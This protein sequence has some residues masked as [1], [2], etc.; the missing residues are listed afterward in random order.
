LTQPNAPQT[1][2]QTPNPVTSFEF[3][4]QV[5]NLAEAKKSD[6]TA[7]LDVSQISGFA[8][9]F[10]F[11]T[12]HSSTQ[13]T[14]IGHHIAEMLKTQGVV[15]LHYEDDQSGQ[16]HL[17]DYGDVV[18]HVMRDEARQHYDLEAYWSHGS[19]LSRDEWMNA[20]RNN[21]QQQRQSA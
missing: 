19:P 14:A 9:Y 13:I 16:W 20:G 10:V 3:A 11:A 5:A 21:A 8:D 17:L 6:N 4:C 15:P 12:G 18:V 2:T 7:I 1:H